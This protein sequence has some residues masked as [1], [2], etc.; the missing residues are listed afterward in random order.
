MA[1]STTTRTRRKKS[2]AAS[3][4]SHS[5][6]DHHLPS[7][8]TPTAKN[9]QWPALPITSIYTSPPGHDVVYLIYLQ[10]VPVGLPLLLFPLSLGK[11]SG[12]YCCNFVL[13][14]TPHSTHCLFDLHT[15]TMRKPS[16]PSSEGD[17]DSE[18]GYVSGV[19]SEASIPDIY[20]TKPHIAFLNRQLQNL[21][22]QGMFH[23]KSWPHTIGD[24]HSRNPTMVHHNAPV[25]VSGD[26][27]WS[28]RPY[29]P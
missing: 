7:L 29:H 9:P 4:Q 6:F 18:S 15:S 28:H 14:V 11:P 19:S 21:E 16:S 3:T 10:S 24:S 5:R 12:L 22:P 8:P 27:L 26:C 1:L 17:R 25:S 2:L 20:L 13:A 23:Q